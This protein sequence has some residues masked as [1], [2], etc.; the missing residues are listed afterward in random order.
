MNFGS[1][2]V[3]QGAGAIAIQADGSIVAAGSAGS[4]TSGTDFALARYV[5]A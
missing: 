1:N 5:P 4:S 3:A 2:V